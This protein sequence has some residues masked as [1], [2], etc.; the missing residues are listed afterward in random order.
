MALTN[1]L[2]SQP[3]YMN[4]WC[5]W[6]TPREQFTC[7]NT[8][9]TSTPRRSSNGPSLHSW[10]RV[11]FASLIGTTI[12]WY[13][14][15]ILDTAAA[16]VFQRGFGH[17]D[18]KTLRSAFGTKQTSILT[19]NMSAFG[20]RTDVTWTLRDVSALDPKRTFGSKERAAALDRWIARAPS[21][22]HIAPWAG[23]AGTL[24]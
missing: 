12:E 14:L 7:Q 19:L 15:L 8:E 9:T 3:T 1:N 24:K 5:G 22:S 17:G 16:L 2:F 13:E 23:H 6:S 18:G 21:L 20:G 10:R 4:V 11:A